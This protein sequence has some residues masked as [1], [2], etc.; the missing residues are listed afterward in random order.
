MLV[1]VAV[2]AALNPRVVLGVPASTVVRTETEV[3]EA[4]ER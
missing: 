3:P 1:V 2:E 4:P